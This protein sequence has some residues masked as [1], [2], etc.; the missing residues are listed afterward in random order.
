MHSALT[1]DY[2]GSIPLPLTKFWSIVSRD[3]LLAQLAEQLTLNQ[4]VPGSTPGRPTKI[5]GNLCCKQIEFECIK[6]DGTEKKAPLF[7]DLIATIRQQPDMETLFGIRGGLT[8]TRS[9]TQY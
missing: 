3:G 6:A 5:R 8:L 7:E 1:R 9:G 4:K 2:E